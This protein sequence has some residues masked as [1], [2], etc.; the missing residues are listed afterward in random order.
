MQGQ[1]VSI[2][3]GLCGVLLLCEALKGEVVTV[4]IALI[5]ISSSVTFSGV[6]NGNIG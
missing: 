1:F 5:G 2:N 3:V 6:N 4:G